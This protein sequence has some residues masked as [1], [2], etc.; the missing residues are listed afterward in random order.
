MKIDTQVIRNE[1]GVFFILSW[2]KGSSCGFSTID[3][4]HGWDHDAVQATLDM[5][6][7]KLQ[8]VLDRL[9]LDP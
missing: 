5:V 2:S 8:P 4:S 7:E 9:P 1:L 6:T 3:F